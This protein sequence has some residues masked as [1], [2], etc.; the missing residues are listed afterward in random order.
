MFL[1]AEIIPQAQD[2]IRQWAEVAKQLRTEAANLPRFGDVN[3]M[4][5]DVLTKRS[6]LCPL[7]QDDL[8]PVLK[9]LDQI[10]VHTKV[11]GSGRLDATRWNTGVRFACRRAA[12]PSLKPLSRASTI[13]WRCFQPQYPKRTGSRRS[14]HE[15]QNKSSQSSGVLTCLSRKRSSVR[16]RSGTLTF[17]KLRQRPSGETGR[18]ATLRK[19]CHHGVR[20]RLSPWPLE[21]AQN[22]SQ[23]RRVPHA[24]S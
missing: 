12:T 2:Q 18:H 14:S 20:V 11:V 24:V 4:A 22:T 23:V 5:A 10:T 3:E 6:W 7:K 1:D 13:S 8:R 16:I 15:F 17:H 19:S 21:T 9:G